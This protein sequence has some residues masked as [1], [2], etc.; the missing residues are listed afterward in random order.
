MAPLDLRVDLGSVQR[1]WAFTILSMPPGSSLSS[2]DD[3]E[4]ARARTKELY[5]KR[6]LEKKDAEAAKVIEAFE[7]LKREFKAASAAAENRA[8]LTR[9]GSSAEDLAPAAKK[10]RTLER[11]GSG[12][13]A[14]AAAASGL[15][16]GEAAA[17]R[18]SWAE[19]E[20]SKQPEIPER[21]H[22][23]G[24]QLCA[25]V[26]AATLERLAAG[27]AG[28]EAEGA[29]AEAPMAPVELVA[30]PKGVIAVV[31]ATTPKVKVQ[32]APAK[33]GAAVPAKGPLRQCS[34]LVKVNLPLEEMQAAGQDVEVRVCSLESSSARLELPEYLRC[35]ING[36]RGALKRRSA[37]NGQC[38]RGMVV[39][40]SLRAGANT[41]GVVLRDAKVERFAF[42]LVR[43]A[44]PSRPAP[45]ADAPP[46]DAEP[47]ASAAARPPAEDGEILAEAGED[48]EGAVEADGFALVSDAEGEPEAA[49]PEADAGAEAPVSGD[50][51]ASAPAAAAPDEEETAKDA[52]EKQNRCD[53]LRQKLREA[54]QQHMVQQ[55][56]AEVE[57]QKRTQETKEAPAAK[58]SEIVAIDDDDANAAS[59]PEGNVQK[60]ETG[61][62]A[63]QATKSI[64][65]A[66]V[67]NK[68]D[69]LQ[70][71]KVKKVKTVADAAEKTNQEPEKLVEKSRKPGEKQAE[72]VLKPP[73]KP[74]EKTSKPEK[75]P[76]KASSLSGAAPEKTVHT[77]TAEPP[78]LAKPKKKA[79]A[80]VAVAAAPTKAVESSSA[81]SQSESSSSGSSKRAVKKKVKRIRRRSRSRSKDKERRE[82]QRRRTGGR[83]RR[84]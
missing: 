47:E 23:S 30:G 54:K 56:K 12:G 18:A 6:M 32:Y 79:K 9:S 59:R 44:V 75:P 34:F 39:T 45:D 66:A 37:G 26:R 70:K 72:Q 5:K 74:P 16:R 2:K 73:E 24:E 14:G 36:Q 53:L 69:S 46:A 42:A 27:A 13:A 29:G 11:Q 1:T 22:P 55:Q 77:S 33:V 48:D 51:D 21:T 62:V 78:N 80:A 50:V 38:A 58:K 68:G 67:E 60:G 8:K 40:S 76:E 4:S 3:L 83:G 57:K 71:P 35:D 63:K 19:P 41:V 20:A 10:A 15:S 17:L 61:G 81:S 25:L 82:R 31:T 49:E 65:A 84:R 7:T 28:A 52:S 43:T 64:A